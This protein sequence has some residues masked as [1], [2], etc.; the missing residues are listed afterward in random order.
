MSTRTENTKRNIIAG[1]MQRIVGIILPFIN[2]TVILYVLGADYTGLTGLFSSLLEVLNIAELGF[3]SAIVYSLYTPMANDDKDK[4]RETVSLFRK[5]YAI[6]GTIILCGGLATM[7]FLKRL[8]NGSYPS[9]INLYLLFFLY[10]LNTVVSYFLFAFKECLLIADQRKDISDNIRTSI[11]VGRYILQFLV[12]ILTHNFYLYICASII[13]TIVTNIC[14]QVVTRKRYS[15]YF[16][17]K[18]KIVFPDKIKRQVKGL[19]IDR[20]GD[21]CRNSF[22]SIIVS[23]YLGLKFTAIYGN[24]YYIYSALYAIMLVLCNAMSASVGN[25]IAKESVKKNYEDLNKFTFIF[26]W[27]AGWSTVCLACLYQPFMSIWAG[28]TLLL[29][30][31]DMLLFCLYFYI[32]NMTNIRNQYISG[33]GMWWK[34]K[35]PCM[36]EAISNLLLNIILGKLFGVTGVIIATIIT[37]LILNFSWRTLILFKEYFKE[38]FLN[39]FLKYLYYLFITVLITLISYCFCNQIHI[40]GWMGLLIRLMVCIIIPNILFYLGYRP[41]KQFDEGVKFLRIIAERK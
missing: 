4:I 35:L 6:I 39:Y 30:N 16:D 26:S 40:Q 13:G 1:L 7:P 21:A 3:N 10:L 41:L 28:K 11:S 15:Y 24:Y 25:S 29:S 17:I 8:I 18:G 37:I 2:R 32:I 12:L 38:N 36:C 31:K 5:V 14:I 19:F 27:I 34:L 23:Y 20:I 33:T 9:D 22:D